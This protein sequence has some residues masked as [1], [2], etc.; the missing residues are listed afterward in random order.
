MTSGVFISHRSTDKEIAD[1]LKD[2]FVSVE[3]PNSSVFCSSL[4]GNDIEQRI[5]GEVKEGLNNSIV[6]IAILS[7]DY[8]ESAYCMNEA[9]I[10]WFLGK[11][12]IIVA[13]PEIEPS[14]MYGF[15]NGEYKLRRLDQESDIAAIYDIVRV[16]LNTTQAS[17]A[18]TN[19]AIQKLIRRYSKYIKGRTVPCQRNTVGMQNNPGL[20]AEES[21]YIISTEKQ[22]FIS[23]IDENL[24]KANTLL[25]STL[26]YVLRSSLVK[27]SLND[28]HIDRFVVEFHIDRMNANNQSTV[29]VDRY[30]AGQAS[31][32]CK[33]IVVP[34]SHSQHKERKEYE[35]TAVDVNTQHKMMHSFG[36][37]NNIEIIQIDLPNKTKKSFNVLLSIEDNPNFPSFYDDNK[38]QAFL[39]DPFFLFTE[40][41]YTQ[42]FFYSDDE[43]IRNRIGRLFFVNKNSY[44]WEQIED[45]SFDSKGVLRFEVTADDMKEYKDCLIVVLLER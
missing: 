17:E 5:S 11:D 45:K 12:T 30:F 44:T 25:P 10:I 18:V 36:I 22:R 14:K 42:M 39:G 20:A 31:T 27:G 6:N 37:K 16:S 35:Y 34:F 1:M 41:E 21:E 33:S 3:I 32:S 2:F 24:I 19:A 15:L 38:V 23:M 13:L 40:W 43:H 26:K 9:G 8:Y 7:Q 4:P 28:M 29:K